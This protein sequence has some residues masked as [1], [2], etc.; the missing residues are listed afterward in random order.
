M[1]IQKHPGKQIDLLPAIRAHVPS[2][3]TPQLNRLQE[4][5][6]STRIFHGFLS[7]DWE[8]R[9]LEEIAGM[10]NELMDQREQDARDNV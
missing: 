6:K 7:S 5:L 3:D 1:E 4:R 9:P 2:P 10:L 8:H